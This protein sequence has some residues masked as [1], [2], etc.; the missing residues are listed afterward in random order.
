LLIG[1]RGCVQVYEPH[2]YGPSVVPDV[3]QHNAPDFPNNLPAVWFQ[4]WAFVE[5]F[6][7]NAEVLGEWG[8]FYVGKDRVWH[9]EFAAFMVR[10]CLNDNFYWGEWLMHSFCVNTESLGVH[11]QRPDR[12]REDGSFPSA[13]LCRPRFR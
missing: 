1:G 4:N 6:T 11:H 8:G 3:P 13:Q 10:N 5:S 7:G 9:E 12:T 2:N